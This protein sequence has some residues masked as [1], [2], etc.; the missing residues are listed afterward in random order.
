MFLGI[1]STEEETHSLPISQNTIAPSAFGHLGQR[2]I[3]SHRL[4]WTGQRLATG[5]CW[6][7]GF[8]SQ[9]WARWSYFL[10]DPCSEYRHSPY[11]QI[12]YLHFHLF[13]V[14]T[15]CTLLPFL[16]PVEAY[17]FLLWKECFV[18]DCNIF[19]NARRRIQ[20]KLTE[21]ESFHPRD[22]KLPE[23]LKHNLISRPRFLSH[24]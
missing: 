9:A 22:R 15:P 3:R 8:G 20:W 18:K 23:T 4:T 17:M 16:V 24:H 10:F 14:P 2:P 6:L 5:H 7:P 11:L 12:Q 1:L 13:M 21:L 19:L